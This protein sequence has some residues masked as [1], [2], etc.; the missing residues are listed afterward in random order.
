MESFRLRFRAGKVSLQGKK[1][2]KVGVGKK[3]LGGSFAFVLSGALADGLTD[4]RTDRQ[5]NG[6]AD[7]QND[8]PMDRQTDTRSFIVWGM[9]M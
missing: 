1:E 6:P 9:G 7:R 3:I 5:T 8:K 4:G 2:K